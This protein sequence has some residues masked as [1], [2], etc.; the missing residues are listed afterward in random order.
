M[1]KIFIDPQGQEYDVPDDPSPHELMEIKQRGLKPKEQMGVAED[2]GRSTFSGISEGLA[3][4]PLIAGDLLRLAGHVGN[5][6]APGQLPAFENFGSQAWIDAFRDSPQHKFL[7]KI[8]PD[9]LHEPQTTAGR[10]AKPVASAISGAALTGGV[11]GIGTAGAVTGTKAALTPPM[12]AITGGS[13]AAGQGV[14]DL[15]DNPL[16]GM[17]ATLG[18]NTAGNLA[19]RGMA[20]NLDEVVYDATKG[21]DKR[22]W[23]ESRRHLQKYGES[24]SDTFTLADLPH[25]QPRMGGVARSTAA[26]AGGDQ[27]RQKFSLQD[28]FNRDIPELYGR[29]AHEIWPGAVSGPINQR[30]NSIISSLRQVDP[31]R[32]PNVVRSL[33]DAEAL[34]VAKMMADRLRTMPNKASA[35]FDAKRDRDVLQH[36]LERVDKPLADS[37]RNKVDV[38]DSLSRLGAPHASDTTLD[39]KQSRNPVQWM[40]SPFGTAGFRAGLRT[41]EKESRNLSELLSNPTPQNLEQLR[42]LSLIDPRAKKALEWVSSLMGS[43]Q[44]TVPSQ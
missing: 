5:K 24:G 41:N 10:Y 16:L 21:M 1:P 26:T 23:Q 28:R 14:T 15:T 40:T 2:V 34:Q 38:G 44:S 42:R 35:S 30:A 33:S 19:R 18:T 37:V 6:I 17:L 20:P 43:A 8:M 32:L 36:L 25:L 7:N 9:V 3:R 11:G 39:F 27:L 31:Q 12:L 22:Q 4:T 29:A 13:A